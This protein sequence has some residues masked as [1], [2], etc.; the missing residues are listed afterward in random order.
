V[1]GTLTRSEAEGRHKGR[2]S[3]FWRRRDKEGG[4][5]R[6]SWEE[7]TTTAKIMITITRK[8]SKVIMTEAPKAR[9]GK[10]STNERK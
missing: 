2:Y 1:S 3:R 5:S 4:W 10:R 6:R 9:D 8:S 7:E